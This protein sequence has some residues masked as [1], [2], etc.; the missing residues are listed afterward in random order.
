MMVSWGVSWFPFMAPFITPRLVLSV[1]AL[2]T[3]LN[4][5]LSSNTALP[6]GAPFNW[7]DCFNQTLLMCMFLTLL[8][9][10]F[11]EILMHQLKLEELARSV[12]H[13]NKV[14]LPFVSLSS[15]GIILMNI[16][17]D[18]YLNLVNTS[19][20]VKIWIVVT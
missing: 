17:P 9:T 19:F 15:L 6:P 12:N 1:M 5:S 7:N 18:G 2:M 8:L 4:L 16:G 11:A 13:E 20:V 3:F 10:I 14:V